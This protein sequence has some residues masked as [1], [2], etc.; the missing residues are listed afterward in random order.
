MYLSEGLVAVVFN[1]VLNT[2]RFILMALLR[3]HVENES[4]S[5]VHALEQIIKLWATFALCQGSY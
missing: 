4:Q 5:A 2:L 3:Q 1:I